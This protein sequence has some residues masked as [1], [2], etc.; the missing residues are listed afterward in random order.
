[1]I[2]M[3]A[4]LSAHKICS[5]TSYNS[6]SAASEI[7]LQPGKQFFGSHIFDDRQGLIVQDNKLQNSVRYV[8][9][10]LPVCGEFISS[11]EARFQSSPLQLVLL[12]PLCF[13]KFVLL[14][15]VTRL[16]V[17]N[18]VAGVETSNTR[19]TPWKFVLA[20]VAGGS[21]QC[22]ILPHRRHDAR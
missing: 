22:E 19:A 16:Q 3:H 4:G 8:C 2:I 18:Q 10:L 1:M 17:F 11:L 5:L 20:Y 14:F 15:I 21:I 6:G 13:A 9:C 7:N 12:F